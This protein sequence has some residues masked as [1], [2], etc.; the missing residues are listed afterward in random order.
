MLLR[1]REQ[2]HHVMAPMMI[3][4]VEKHEAAGEENLTDGVTL[5]MGPEGEGVSPEDVWGG[6]EL[7]QHPAVERGLGKLWRAGFRL[8]WSR[9]RKGQQK[10]HLAGELRVM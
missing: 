9:M 10:K 6:G 7:A 4:T 5:E 2:V 8:G 1:E 3:K